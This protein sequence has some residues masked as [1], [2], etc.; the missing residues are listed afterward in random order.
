M[1]SAPS[2]TVSFLGTGEIDED[3][4]R[5]ALKQV[6]LNESNRPVLCHP[7]TVIVAMTGLSEGEVQLL[8]ERYL[9][10][11]QQAVISS[12]LVNSVLKASAGS[13]FWCA[14][15]AKF[16]HEH[17]VEEFMIS[18]KGTQTG[19]TFLVI[20]LLEKLSTE[21]QTIARHA[22]IV[23]FQFSLSL[24][25]AVLP[26]KPVIDVA[27]V[28]EGLQLLAEEGFV[29]CVETTEKDVIYNFRNDFIAKALYQLSPPSEASRIHASAALFIEQHYQEDLSPHYESLSYHCRRC[30]HMEDQRSR[31]FRYTCLAAE[32]KVDSG[33]FGQ[34][35]H[36]CS[37][38][39]TLAF[40]VE[41]LDALERILSAGYEELSI[42]K[43]LEAG[44]S[45]DAEGK[46]AVA[47]AAMEE[48]NKS[49][50]GNSSML[51]HYKMLLMLVTEKKA[52]R[53]LQ[54]K[55]EEA[56][57]IHQELSA[58]LVPDMKM[59]V[60]D[61]NGDVGDG[62][63]V[64]VEEEEPPLTERGELTSTPSSNAFASL[65]RLLGVTGTGATAGT[66]MASAASSTPHSIR[67][68]G[69]GGGRV[70]LD[71][72][73]MAAMN[74]SGQLSAQG[75]MD[76]ETEQQGTT[77][78]PSAPPFYVFGS[79][80]DDSRTTAPTSSSSP[81]RDYPTLP[82]SPT[83]PN[84]NPATDLPS[85]LHH[86]GNNHHHQNHNGI[87]SQPH[88][89]HSGHNSSNNNNNNNTNNPR[90][91]NGSGSGHNNSKESGTNRDP[92]FRLLSNESNYQS[93]T[94]AT[95][96]LTTGTTLPTVTP[97]T[98]PQTGKGPGAGAG[99][100][101]GVNNSDK[102]G[103]GSTKS[104]SKDGAPSSKCLQS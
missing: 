1:H 36:L 75:S 88:Q 74:L 31:S 86:F 91:T 79:V 69:G 34:C 73:D 44:S 66:N 8:L 85:L 24:L 33:A 54:Q 78:A 22:S 64:G 59:E 92:L 20:C 102:G 72:D 87:N 83:N 39:L 35:L 103:G 65:V 48:S 71:D 28:K 56:Y 16:I 2:D 62:K 21:A 17:S 10:S 55:Q 60:A 27:K 26:K 7:D 45:F 4:N 93:E 98:A 6:R 95:T 63:S 40:A 99:A 84:P 67:V 52:T 37:S 96:T 101:A 57:R 14:T 70:V 58:K 29:V 51:H 25:Q 89:Q 90:S 94:A 53:A 32:Y 47:A 38:A 49:N 76:K 3:P 9:G 61:E 5:E 80:S 13:P 43:M 46:H 41:E 23:G 18:I 15:I 12:E 30:I 42:V 81:T 100:V 97:T 77:T 11:S 19:L 104:N 82:S 50:K 68:G